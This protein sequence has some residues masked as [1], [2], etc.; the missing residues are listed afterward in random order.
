MDEYR[1]HG[2]QALGEETGQQHYRRLYR[3]YVNGAVAGMIEERGTPPTPRELTELMLA[4]PQEY[5]A[6]TGISA[7]DLGRLL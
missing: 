6:I 4:F 5:R 1:V 7:E 3:A 2:R